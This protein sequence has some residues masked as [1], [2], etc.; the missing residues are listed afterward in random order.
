MDNEPMIKSS[1]YVPQNLAFL[2]EI[3]EI[4]QSACKRGEE[5]IRI[6]WSKVMS[7]STASFRLTDCCKITSFLWSQVPNAKLFEDTFHCDFEDSTF[8]SQL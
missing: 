2:K 6:G 7:V 3:P 8:S 5:R 1:L 4:R